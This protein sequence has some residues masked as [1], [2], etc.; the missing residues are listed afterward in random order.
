MEG[1]LELMVVLL[2]WEHPE[3]EDRMKAK[4]M[5]SGSG[6]VPHPPAQ[7]TCP[8]LPMTTIQTGA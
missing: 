7:R 6:R 8:L 5:P 2:G 3:G 1:E 4:D